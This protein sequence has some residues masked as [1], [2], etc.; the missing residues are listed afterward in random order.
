[1]ISCITLYMT[2]WA[3]LYDAAGTAEPASFWSRF[4]FLPGET[5][6]RPAR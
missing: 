1:M 6:R 5:A 4:G 2:Q 3:A